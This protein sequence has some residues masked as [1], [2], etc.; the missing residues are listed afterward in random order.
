VEKQNVFAQLSSLFAELL[1]SVAVPFFVSASFFFD[2]LFS[3]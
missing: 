2:L 1:N 3:V